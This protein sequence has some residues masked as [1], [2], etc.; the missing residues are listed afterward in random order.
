[1]SESAWFIFGGFSFA[2]LMLSA[3]F[4]VYVVLTWRQDREEATRPARKGLISVE[5]TN[6]QRR[7]S[8]PVAS[9]AI[10]ALVVVVVIVLTALGI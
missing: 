6:A 8:G 9:L 7:S 4:G 10:M 5:E 3:A 2:V 1:M